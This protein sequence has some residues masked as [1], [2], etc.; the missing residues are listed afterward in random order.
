MP[1][2]RS[3]FTDALTRGVLVF[4]GAMGTEIYRHHVFTNR[5]FDELC[6]SDPKLIETIHR[7]YC[8][9]GADVLTTNTFGAQR[10]SLEKYG[11][12][13]KVREI[14]RAGAAI[15]RRVADAADR[16]VL[17]AGSIGPVATQRHSE[18]AICETIAQQVA[19]LWEGGADFI[20]F[21]TQPSRA[22]LE[23]CAAAMRLQPEVPFILSCMLDSQGESV[24]G[25]PIE[26]L[27]APLPGDGPQPVAWGL[28]C[29][30]GPDGLL[31][32]VERAVRT[33]ALPL[34]VQ[35]NAGMPKE[36]DNRRIYFCS[37]EYLTEYAKRF[38]NLGASGVGGCCG[39][40]PEHIREMS[41]TIKPLSRRRTAPTVKPA[42][43]VPLKPAAALGEKSQLGKRLAAGQWVTTVELVPPRGYDLG[44]TVAKSS[45]L[46][47]RGVTAINIP[48]GPRASARI[49]PLITAERILREAQIEP[50]LHFC[51]RD[52][53]L[54]GMQADLLACAACGVRNILFVTGDPPKLGDYPHATGVFDADSIGM[55][56][57]QKRLNQGVDL[58][59]QSIDPQTF[60]V[61]GVGLDP[62]ALDRKR[63]IDRFRQKVESGAEFAI[64]Q[65]VFDPGAL[66]RMLDDVQHHGIPIVAGIW[67]LVS[68]RNALF[69]RNEVPGVVVPD[70]VMERMA[71]VT[72]REDQL[73]VGIQIAR[74]SVTRVR[75]RVAGIQV[76]AP[77]GNIETAW[78]VIEE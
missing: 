37:P 35:P 7:D 74:E 17:V 30:T 68:Y 27:L 4:D 42:A 29:G 32:A 10:P 12:A 72:T 36:V 31:G 23:Q 52:R 24:A 56:A 45:T 50:I 14:N 63:E 33:I 43:A 47:D 65:P 16:P 51:C 19:A 18:E 69:M 59:G 53:N 2:N 13:D 61:I 1:Q 58:G 49:S 5:S 73:A 46:R 6:L 76:S 26:N 21:E 54:I 70:T 44:S 25:E 77:L 57:V 8:E 39:T 48:D 60:A 9:A 3:G 34:I 20:I 71:A 22:A 41:R 40:A 78:A 64:T 28:N 62:T 38:V 55:A 15:A 11:L 66:L 67:P 75:D